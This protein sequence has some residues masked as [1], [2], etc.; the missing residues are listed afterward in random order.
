[1]VVSARRVGESM[2]RSLW[3]DGVSEK[4][5]HSIC[6]ITYCRETLRMASISRRIG[7]VTSWLPAA[8][9]SSASCIGASPAPSASAA[10][11]FEPSDAREAAESRRRWVGTFFSLVVGLEG[12]KASATASWMAASSPSS[13]AAS[14]AAAASRAA[15]GTSEWTVR[16]S[17]GGRGRWTC[18]WREWSCSVTPTEAAEAAV[19]AARSSRCARSGERAARA[20]GW[21]WTCAS[22]E[23]ASEETTMW[24]RGATCA[25]S[26][27]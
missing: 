18:D 8:A 26:E 19:A 14:A 21:R 16:R 17:E 6:R 15:G 22:G 4:A 20:C 10:S 5:C 7:T 2:A 3:S 23:E 11:S 27:E 9:A 24:R 25:W 1:M 13:A 12:G